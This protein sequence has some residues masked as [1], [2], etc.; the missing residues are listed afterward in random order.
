MESPSGVAPDFTVQ[1]LDGHQIT[2]S[3]LKGK[4]VLL[5]FWATW[6][7]P[8]RESIP[9]LVQLYQTYGKEGFELI[10]VSLDRG[11][12]ETVRNF[13]K[14]MAI[15]YPITIAPEEMARK[16]GVTALP[17]T[18]LIDKDGTILLKVAGFSPTLAKEIT[19]KV[20]DLTSG[21]P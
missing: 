8:C 14:R 21:K 15:P 5:D 18:I 4:T 7:G 11:D 1:T 19:A 2:L 3:N 6:C 10:G 13:V 20:G 9:H 12:P 17:T 16:Y